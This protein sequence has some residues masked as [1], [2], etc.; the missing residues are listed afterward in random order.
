MRAYIFLCYIINGETWWHGLGGIDFFN[1]SYTPFERPNDRYT[2]EYR[3]GMRFVT[4]CIVKLYCRVTLC[5]TCHILILSN[6]IS[7][8][9]TKVIS[10]IQV[11][12]DVTKIPDFSDH[13]KVNCLFFTREKGCSL[14]STRS[15]KISFLIRRDKIY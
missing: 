9:G 11:V 12:R 5:I 7:H 4:W 10:W 6:D 2:S 15:N 1:H 13:I 3:H 8:L 14:K